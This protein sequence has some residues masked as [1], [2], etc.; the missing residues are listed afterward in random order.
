MQTLSSIDV[1]VMSV[2]AWRGLN[3]LSFG[4]AA[5][6]SQILVCL[7][8]RVPFLVDLKGSRKGIDKDHQNHFGGSDS[9]KRTHTQL[10][11]KMNRGSLKLP[12][13]MLRVL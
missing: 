2:A 12:D 1:D 8:L 9:W 3:A 13:Q 10:S 6:S 5:S 4:Q 7:C 11:P